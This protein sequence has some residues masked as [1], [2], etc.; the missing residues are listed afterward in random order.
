MIVKSCFNILIEVCACVQKKLFCRKRSSYSRSAEATYYIMVPLI[1]NKFGLRL[2]F[3]KK[4]HFLHFNL[5]PPLKF[6]LTKFFLFTTFTW[7]NV[8]Q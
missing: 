8:L 3:A 4:R 7:G 2:G 1:R 5:T 6:A